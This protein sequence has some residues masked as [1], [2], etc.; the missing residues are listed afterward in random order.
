MISL[1]IFTGISL[2]TSPEYPLRILTGISEIP[3][4][5][6]PRIPI[7]ITLLISPGISLEMSLWF[8]SAILPWIS[9]AISP[10]FLHLCFPGFLG[11]Y[12]RNPSAIPPDFFGVLLGILPGILSLISLE[13]PLDLDIS[14][15]IAS[16]IFSGIPSVPE[17]FH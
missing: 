11:I 4:W 9:S 13:I 2:E 17:F 6:C 16:G 7:R 5:S 10:G 3:R 8:P 14:D 15:R 12:P 1:R